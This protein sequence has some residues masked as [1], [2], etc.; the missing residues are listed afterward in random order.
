M[1]G[2][3][4]TLA[5]AR[6]KRGHLRVIEGGAGKGIVSQPSVRSYLHWTPRHL[7][8]LQLTADGGDLSRLGDLADQMIADDRIDKLLEDLSGG[9]FGCDLTFERDS[10]STLG[11]AEKA[12]ELEEDWPLGWAEDEL[13]SFLGWMMIVGI[14]FARHDGFVQSPAS[15][16]IVPV[17]KTWHPKHFRF[18]WPKSRWF[19]RDEQ[20]RESPVTPGDG[21]WIVGTRRGDYRPWAHGLWRGLSPWWV[22]KRYAIADW[23]VHSEKASKL[24]L[25]AG[26]GAMPEDRKR[27]ANEIFEL[28]KDAV[29][30]LPIGFKLSLVELEANTQ[31]IYEAQIKAAEM[32]MTLAILGQ[33]LTSIVEGGSYAAAQSHERK[34][35][36]VFRYAAKKIGRTLHEQSLPIWAE[37]NFGDRTLAPF[38]RWQTDPPEDKGAKVQTL[39]TLGT[40]LT[41]LKSAGFGMSVD[42]IEEQYGI[43]LEVVAEPEPE[44]EEI[45]EEEEHEEEHEEELDD[46]GDEELATRDAS[47][48][49]R[50]FLSGQLYADKLGE[51]S[52]EAAAEAMEG[53]VSRLNEAV[54][55]ASDYTSARAAI[56]A[57]FEDE[58]D[59]DRLEQIV[60]AGIVMA[61]LAGRFAV[62]E[63][64]GELDHEDDEDELHA[65]GL[66]DAQLGAFQP[67][68][69]KLGRFAPM[70]GSGVKKQ[71]TSALKKHE[72]GKRAPAKKRAAA[73]SLERKKTIAKKVAK[74]KAAVRA[75]AAT[76]KAAKKPATKRKPAAKTKA[77]PALEQKKAAAKKT[78]AAKK[79]PKKPAPKPAPKKQAAD[80][81]P[82][83]DKA[84]AAVVKRLPD[85][86]IRRHT[87]M[88]IADSLPRVRS[89]SG[90]V[91]DRVWIDD[92]MTATGYSKKKVAQQWADGEIR[93]S[94][95]DLVGV[96]LKQKHRIDASE[97]QRMEATA[98]WIHASGD[99]P[100]PLREK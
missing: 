4:D 85:D 32:G 40:A 23:G 75:A 67:K 98:H 62:R 97:I 3:F 90:A 84:G 16:R 22:L 70:A 18:D 30:S 35:L 87:S 8:S 39:A 6:K 47:E 83:A 72:K 24:V 88:E 1:T 68:R 91:W 26:P 48:P 19:V 5:T 38:P 29:I 99:D 34:E 25:E 28:A 79:S 53:F 43:R 89:D 66:T 71:A 58:T 82:K 36:R 21:E 76:K 15:E 80:E 37:F 56:L 41:A 86:V 27:L 73:S 50:G 33:N 69:D 92:Y 9:V 14:A 13:S 78:A 81:T 100:V 44:P 51:A 54:A 96:F 63:D 11:D 52:T 57:A 17:Y 77:S 45:E 31:A 10:R 65:H 94:R 2:E 59:P 55:G 42:D 20:G 64:A 60:E 61:H 95:L 12:A 7:Q 93:V 74:K 49:T 46:E